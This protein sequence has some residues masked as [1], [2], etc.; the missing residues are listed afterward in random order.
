MKSLSL[1][2]T[3]SDEEVGASSSL[4]APAPAAPSSSDDRTARA[5]GLDFFDGGAGPFLGRAAGGAALPLGDRRGAAT[6]AA[7]LAL[8]G[9]AALAVAER[10]R[11]A[12][13]GGGAA[14]IGVSS[15]AVAAAGGAG[16]AS[17][18]LVGGACGIG[19]ADDRNV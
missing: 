3:S 7:G 17:P 6:A 18:A 19:V 9:V 11:L 10:G 16:A 8:A 2:S 1:A 15:A 14:S 5:A 13:D 4:A 12:A